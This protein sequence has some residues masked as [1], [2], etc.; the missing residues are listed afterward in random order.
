[1]A[2]KKKNRAAHEGLVGGPLLIHSIVQLPPSRRSR[3]VRWLCRPSRRTWCRGRISTTPASMRRTSGTS[4]SASTA[5]SGGPV[6]DAVD[7]YYISCTFSMCRSF[8]SIEEP[9]GFI[10]RY[11][12]QGISFLSEP[13]LTTG[14]F[15]P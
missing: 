15:G 13:P 8:C 14:S 7:K 12:A 4:R 5:R 11:V 6:D 9:R 10:A 3:A 2:S 1:M